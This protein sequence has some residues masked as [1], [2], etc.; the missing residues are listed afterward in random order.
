MKSR[1]LW[2]FLMLVVL[3]LGWLANNIWYKPFTIAYFFE[4]A[5]LQYGLSH[6]EDLSRVKFLRDWGLDWYSG[7]LDDLSEEQMQQD[8]KQ[9]LRNLDM[10]RSYRR[11]RLNFQEKLSADV[12]EWHYENQ[13]LGHAFRYHAEPLNHLNGVHI[14]LPE[15]L[16]E[17]HDINH[18]NDA[19]QYL[20]RLSLMGEKVEQLIVFQ[21]IKLE[22]GHRMSC[23]VRDA[24]IRQLNQ[25]TI[26]SPEDH[27]L[28]HDFRLKIGGVNVLTAEARQDLI[29]QAASEL[30]NLVYPAYEKLRVFLY[31]MP[32]TDDIGG[33]NIMPQGS[34]YYN[35]LLRLHSTTEVQ[36]GTLHRESLAEAARLHTLFAD[37]YDS[38]QRNQ[39]SFPAFTKSYE[40]DIDGQK[41]YLDDLKISL[42]VLEKKLSYLFED[43]MP[44]LV[45][46]GRTPSFMQDRQFEPYIYGVYPRSNSP[47][48]LYVNMAHIVG[49]RSFENTALVAE[50]VF[51]GKM[52][53]RSIQSRIP[54]LPTFRKVIDFKA[55]TDGWAAYVLQVLHE[56]GFFNEEPEA[57]LGLYY[58]QLFAAALLAADTGVH[59]TGWRRAQ[60]RAYLAEKLRLKADELE[61]YT[62][63]V[64]LNPGQAAAYKAGLDKILALRAMAQQELADRFDI[65]QFHAALLQNGALP[66]FLLD[67]VVASHI[68]YMQRD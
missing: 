59:H 15:F 26:K 66:V 29:A 24:V 27:P 39:R 56:T 16:M 20:K 18:L 9:T 7:L 4:R 57:R 10:L 34:A 41:A 52:Y 17:H 22:A 54:S 42:T 31:N 14:E 36:A 49:I 55:Y 65:R 67:D 35:Y 48:R 46:F 3:P 32:C 64:L 63:W 6:P 28:Y 61:Y 33:L 60:A 25:F 38:L 45:S 37:L 12:L 8:Y 53:Q 30:A 2:I 11:S 1:S 68:H 50:Y 40:I 58:R 51:P 19:V 21:K 44:Q 47:A 43:P 62:D 23:Y 5:W 13:L